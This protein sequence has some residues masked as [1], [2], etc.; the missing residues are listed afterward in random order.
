VQAASFVSRVGITLLVILPV[1]LF[2][3]VMIASA[4]TAI[5]PRVTAIANPII[6]PGTVD[7]RS[8]NYSVRPG[9]RG[10]ERFIYC[11]TNDGKESREDVTLKAVFWSFL[12]YSGIA[13]VLLRLIA[14]PLLRRR[15]R[16]ALG[17]RR[18][19]IVAG[20]ATPFAHAAESPASTV[21]VQQ[22]LAQVSEALERG[23]GDVVVRNMRFGM[24]D[25]PGDDTDPAERLAQLKQLYDSGLISAEDYASKK[26]EILARL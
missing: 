14:V 26:A 24:P 4:G 18:V 7:Y 10:V 19:Q 17:S 23:G 2:I 5:Y 1:S 15:F 22:I 8:Q 20:R 6:C 3:G 25:G 16:D 9:E 11:V 12:L 13:F 21:D